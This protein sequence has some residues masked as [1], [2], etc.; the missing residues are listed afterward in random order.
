MFI[1]VP[2]VPYRLE[3]KKYKEKEKKKEKTRNTLNTVGKRSHNFATL[4]RCHKTRMSKHE[5][6]QYKKKNPQLNRKKQPSSSIRA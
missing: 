5:A 2:P 6:S 3:R 1:P 4:T